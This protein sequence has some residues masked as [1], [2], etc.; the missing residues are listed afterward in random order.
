MKRRPYHIS[1]PQDYRFHYLSVIVDRSKNELSASQFYLKED[2][3]KDDFFKDDR[4]RLK[5][6]GRGRT[7]FV[8]KVQTSYP[9]LLQFFHIEVDVQQMNKHETNSSDVTEVADLLSSR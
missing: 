3:F 6:P 2:F 9:Y 4:Q 5:R 1:D 8:G 7:W